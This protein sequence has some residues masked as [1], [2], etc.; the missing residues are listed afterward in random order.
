MRTPVLMV[1]AG[2]GVERNRKGW[3]VGRLVIWQEPLLHVRPIQCHENDDDGGINGLG[4]AEG[5]ANEIYII[6]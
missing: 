5:W 2:D 1:T 3:K 4:L 6:G